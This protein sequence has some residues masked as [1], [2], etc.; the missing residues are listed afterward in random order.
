MLDEHIEFLETSFVKQQGE[1][2]TRGEFALLVLSID[3][4]LASSSVL[5]VKWVTPDLVL[6][7]LAPP[8]SSWVTTSPSTVFTTAGPV[9]N[10]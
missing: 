8:S 5:T 7:T 1:T 2:F 10:M 9:R 6:W 3:P 4:F